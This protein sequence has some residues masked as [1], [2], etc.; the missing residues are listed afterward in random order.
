MREPNQAKK[1]N[2][3][4][5]AVVVVILLVA[6]GVEAFLLT[7][8]PKP[9]VVVANGDGT[10]ATG[11]IKT[12]EGKPKVAQAAIDAGATQSVT[13]FGQQTAPIKIKFYAPLELDWHKKTI[14]LLRD[15]DKAHPGRILVT[16]MPM[17]NEQ[18]DTEMSELGY[19]CA[20]ILVNGTNEFKIGKRAITLTQRPNE[21]SSFYNSE[22]VITIIN[23]ELA[24]QKK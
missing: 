19:K 10:A 17:G 16:L 20:N 5:F 23:Q 7:Q 13:A 24:K 15:Y 4:L 2:K 22:D 18:C 8:S 3:A 1:G 11:R 6:L 9:P 14:G 12:S 21:T